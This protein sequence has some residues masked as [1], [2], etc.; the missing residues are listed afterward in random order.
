[1]LPGESLGI[2]GYKC[3]CGRTHKLRIC[4]SNAGYY[5]GYFCPKEGPISRETDYVPSAV[6]AARALRVILQGKGQY[7]LR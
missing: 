5:L 3:E 1:M 2:Y 4:R 6:T 7:Y